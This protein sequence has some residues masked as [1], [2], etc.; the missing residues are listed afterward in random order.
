MKIITL[1][2]TIA[3][4]LL[5]LT[6]FYGM[7]VDP[8]YQRNSHALLALGLIMAASKVAVFIAIRRKHCV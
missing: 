5:V 8:P 3:M 1:R 6:S 2:S 7:N 4:P